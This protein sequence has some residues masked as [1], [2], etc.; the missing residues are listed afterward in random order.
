MQVLRLGPNF[1]TNI[2]QLSPAM[3]TTLPKCVIFSFLDNLKIDTIYGIEKM[4]SYKNC[5]EFIYSFKLLR[6]S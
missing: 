1:S 6:L 3:Q 5:I 4:A 2:L